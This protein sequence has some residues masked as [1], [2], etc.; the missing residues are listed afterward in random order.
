M[1]ILMIPLFLMLFVTNNP[2]HIVAVVASFFPPFTPFVIMNRIPANPPAP[3][4]EIITAALLLIVSTWLVVRAAAKVFRIGI[5]M[6]GKPPTL[7][8]M[9]RWARQDN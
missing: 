7:P 1:F 5:L 2:D 6:Y 3:L 4:W 9:L 8:E